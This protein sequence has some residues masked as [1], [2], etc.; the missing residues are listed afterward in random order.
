MGLLCWQCL[1][2]GRVSSASTVSHL[3]GLKQDIFP[4]PSLG[5]VGTAYPEV[6]QQCLLAAQLQYLQVYLTAQQ[7][8]QV[9][10]SL[11]QPSGGGIRKDFPQEGE[12]PGIPPDGE[13]E[14]SPRPHHLN[15]Q[16]EVISTLEASL[17]SEREKLNRMVQVGGLAFTQAE[18]PR[19]SVQATMPPSSNHFEN[20][21]HEKIDLQA[22]QRSLHGR[23]QGV[24]LRSN[25][26]VNGSDL[27]SGNNHGPFYRRPLGGLKRLTS[28]RRARRA[29]KVGNPESILPGHTIPPD[30]CLYSQ[31]GPESEI[32]LNREYYSLNDVRPP[33]TYAS[34]IR[35][36]IIQSDEKQLT[37]NEIYNWFQNT[38][39]YF[40][41]NAATWKNAIRTNLSLHKCFVRYEDDFGSY[42]TVDDT[43]FVRRRHLSRGR[44]RHQDVMMM[45]R[46]VSKHVQDVM[47]LD[48]D[49][50]RDVKDVGRDVHEVRSPIKRQESPV[51]QEDSTNVVEAPR[52]QF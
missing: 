19:E 41:R 15:Q 8:Q 1:T 45:D 38:F 46:D 48:R 11:L 37:L 21:F 30:S 6:Q 3:L 17:N 50:S 22:L 13:T 47:N 26:M 42:W 23:R 51:P 27:M 44:P 34:L 31:N 40:R 2:P 52:E 9:M 5:I 16:L 20:G 25:L 43:E 10:G 14:E 28:A 39:A 24:N 12:I 32:D 33:F 18:V 4:I 29:N 49:V 36:A 7:Q 35:Q